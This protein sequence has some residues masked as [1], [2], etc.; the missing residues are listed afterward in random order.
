M[1]I[2][3]KG[4]MHGFDIVQKAPTTQKALEARVEFM[5]KWF[6]QSKK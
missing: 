6:E 4:T 1:T 3:T 2:R 5:K